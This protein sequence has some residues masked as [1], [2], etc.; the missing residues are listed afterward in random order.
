MDREERLR[1]RSEQDSSESLAE[2]PEQ[3]GARLA[4]R[5]QYKRARGAALTV[6][7]RETIDKERRRHRQ[8]NCDNLPQAIALLMSIVDLSRCT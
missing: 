7:Q 3:R 5:R 8:L 2:T 1:R 6:E 4:I